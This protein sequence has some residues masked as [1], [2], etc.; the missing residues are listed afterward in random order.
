MLPQKSELEQRIVELLR[1]KGNR[2]LSYGEVL[3]RLADPEVKLDAVE[4][5]VDDLERE[6]VIVPVRGNRYSLLEFTP[7]HAGRI[8]VHPDGYG[9]VFGGDDPDIYVDRNSMKGAMSLAAASG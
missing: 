3:E 8:K 2:L 5:V 6:G 4:R 9:T 1:Q 7:Y